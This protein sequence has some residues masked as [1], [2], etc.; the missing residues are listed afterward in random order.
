MKRLLSR[1]RDEEKES[2]QYD[3][4]KAVFINT[5]L[6]RS[7]AI[8]HTDDLMN[9]SRQIMRDQK[10][11]VRNHRFIDHDIATGV[12]PDMREHGWE[13]DDWPDLFK[14]IWAADIL[15][16]GSPIWLG[17]PSSECIKLIERLYAHSGEKNNKGQYKFYGKTAGCVITGNEDGIKH[18][19]SLVLYALQHVGYMVPPQADCGWLGEAGPGPSY[20]ET[21]ED[22]RKAGYDNDFTQR[23][24]HFMTW[25]LLHTARMLKDNGGL[26]ALGNVR[27][28]WDCH[29][30]E[31]YPNPEHR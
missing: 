25:N 6:K 21:L 16:V 9:V 4:L 15:V 8:S 19:A 2:K 13:K 26:P 23:N 27:T 30:G 3:D 20:G 14:D 29:R 1:S 22:G 5:T 17:Q 12:Y 7:P 28:D 18:V 10:V 31:N 11:D 24:T